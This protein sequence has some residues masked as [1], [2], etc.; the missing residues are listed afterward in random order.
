MTEADDGAR[1]P[2]THLK[3]RRSSSLSDLPVFNVNMGGR[4][5]TL[6]SEPGSVT[7]LPG[8]ATQPQMQHTSISLSGLVKHLF[9]SAELRRPASGMAG[10][11]DAEVHSV[12]QISLSQRELA[13]AVKRETGRSGSK[14]SISPLIGYFTNNRQQ[15]GS[16]S[17][18]M[19]GEC[20]E[21]PNSSRSFFRFVDNRDLNSWAPS[22][23]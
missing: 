9:G 6:S 8:V 11:T 20:D 3:M 15:L 16:N 2:P 14:S 21:R 12:T 13:N 5:T 1:L 4:R 17:S 23:T 22:S 10:V 18:G 7:S 19:A